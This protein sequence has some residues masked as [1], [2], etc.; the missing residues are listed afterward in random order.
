M[1]NTKLIASGATMTALCVTVLLLGTVLEIG[2][3]ALP[4]FVGVILIPY[5]G[6]YGKKAH[7]TVFMAVSLLS[8]ILIPNIEQNMIFTGFFGWYPIICPAILRLKSPIDLIFKLLIF[9][10]SIISVELLVMKFLV[11]EIFAYE[12]LIFMLILANIAFL[13]Y[14]KALPKL[15]LRLVKFQQYI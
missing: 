10:T 13:I 4:L 3:Y 2:M 7:F 5:G 12:A 6:K 15:Y 8:F 9:N 1:K 11:P 14:D